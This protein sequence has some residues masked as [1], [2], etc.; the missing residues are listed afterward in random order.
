MSDSD[1]RSVPA[2]YATKK[3]DSTGGLVA[4]VLYNSD[5]VGI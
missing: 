1:R 4:E 2:S 5:E 3:V